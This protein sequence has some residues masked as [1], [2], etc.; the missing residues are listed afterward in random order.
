VRVE[1]SALLSYGGGSAMELGHE[2]R[3]ERVRNVAF[4]R[5]DILGVHQYG[6]AFSIRNCDAALIENVLYEDIRV[7]HHYNELIGFRIIK[8][9]YSKSPTRGR[10]RG[11]TLRRVQVD[12][13]P[14]NPGYSLSHLGGYDADHAFEDVLFEDFRYG[15][16]RV[17]R[18]DDF[19]LYVKHTRGLVFR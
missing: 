8:S 18:P 19:D 1:D 2:F 6:S 3:C 4:R 16:Q 5:M 7:E 17:A 11:V 14:H 10:V 13:T 15:G 9:R 12:L